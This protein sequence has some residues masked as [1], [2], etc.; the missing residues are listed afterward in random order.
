MADTVLSGRWKIYYSAEN[1]QKRIERDTSVT[2]TTID[3][4]NTLYSALQDLFDELNQMDDGVPMSA[5]TPTEYTIGIID[6]GSKDPWFIDRTSVEYL[7]GGAL[8]T[9]SWD[10]VTGTNVGI[11]TIT[12]TIGAGTDFVAADIGKTVTNATGGDSGTLLDF[13][14]N[15]SPKV[16]WIRPASNAA[17]NDWDSTSGT[18]AATGGT[19]SVTQAT[20]AVSGGESLWANI[21]TIGTLET[22]THNYIYQNNASLLAYKGTSDWWGDEHIDILVNV[23]ELGTETDEGYIKV[24]ARQYSKTYSY[25]TVDLTAGGRNPIPLQTGKD[26]DNQTGYRTFTGSSGVSDF[27]VGNFIYVGA[28]WATATKRGT[29]T[30]VSGTVAAPVIT[31]YILGDPMTDFANLDAVKEYTGTADGDGTC[32]A[33]TP[34]NAGPANLGTPPTATFGGR[35]TGGTDDINE[36]GTAENYSIA[37]DCNQNSLANVYEWTKYVTRRG[38]TADIDSGSQ[39]IVGESYIGSDTRIIYNTLTGSIADGAV[40]TQVTSGFKGTVVNHNSN[41]SDKI[42]ILRDS[43]G[44]FNQTNNIEVNGSN[45]VTITGA[46]PVAAITP[47]SA[48]PFGTFAGGKFFCAPGVVLTDYLTTD[49]N[50]FQLVDDNNTVRVAPTKVNINVGNT[51]ASDRIAVFRLTGAGGDIDKARYSGTV[52]AAEATTVIID[53]GGGITSDEPGKTTG[54]VLRLVDISANTEYRLRFDS[55][56]SSTFTL[57]S[58]TLTPEAGTNTTT[59]VDTGAFTTAL[60]KVGDLIYNVTRTATS[61]VTSRDN[62]NQVTISPAIASQVSTD[63]IKK[64]VLPIATATDDTV[65]VPFIDLYVTT[66]GTQTVQIVRLADVEVRVRARRS[67]ATAILPFEQDSTVT[68]SGMT[69]SVIRTADTIKT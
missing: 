15:I 3:T 23:K 39:T 42:L 66:A 25:Y 31:Y 56:T 27:D 67:E 55:W 33:G 61:Y 48:A 7:K 53:T 14:T 16:A 13:N 58:A 51:L 36:D 35:A 2:P 52:Q 6:A 37:M 49:L 46:T 40:V 45:F 10:R 44:T 65:Y 60:C 11:V 8:K 69:V 41:S 26:L 9:A 64:N 54:G 30:A 32:T 17:A 63:T 22:N 24:Y 50:N 1:R 12:Y 68:S 28:T 59:I 5:Q 20:A 29:I 62:D 34:A 38:G 57:S 18:V 4:V 21:Y 19:G 43:R 47:I